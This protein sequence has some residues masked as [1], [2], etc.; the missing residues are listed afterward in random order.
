MADKAHFEEF[1]RRYEESQSRQV[2][3]MINESYN[4]LGVP[5][6][7]IQF[8]GGNVMGEQEMR[9]E[10]LGE[11]NFTGLKVTHPENI[12]KGVEFK[13]N[14]GK[15]GAGYLITAHKGS[16][17]V[18]VARFYGA[19]NKEM[20]NAGL[21]YRHQDLVDMSGLS[22]ALAHLLASIAKIG[23]LTESRYMSIMGSYEPF[24]KAYKNYGEFVRKLDDTDEL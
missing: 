20:Y 16:Y 10:V 1:K 4:Q 21:E 13:F 6:E 17:S 2:L 5:P 14:A 8:R 22:G 9:M 15:E 18:P 11:I 24:I 19:G 3:E 7:V 12:L 23:K